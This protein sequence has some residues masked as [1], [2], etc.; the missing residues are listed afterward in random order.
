MR[1]TLQKILG[2]VRKVIVGKDGVIEKVLMAALAPGHVLLEDV[3]GV[4][5][6]TMTLAFAKALGLETRRIQFTSDTM[7]SDVAGFSSYDS[8]AEDFVYKPGAIMTN[9]LLADE[10]NRTSSKTQSALLEAMEEGRVTVDGVTRELPAPFLVLA[11]QNPAGSAGTQLLP[12]SQMDRFVIRTSIGYPDFQSQVSILRDRRDGNPLDK[13]EPVLTRGQLLEIIET[14]GHVFVRDTVY[15]YITSLVEASRTHPMVTLGL[16]PRGALALCRMTKAYALLAGRDYAAPEDAAAVF[17]D[18]AG[19]RLVLNAKA[20][21]NELGS[22][23][24]TDEILA[25][26]NMPVVREI[27]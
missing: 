18:V 26:V 9:L 21:F 23:G 20:R 3:P 19:H 6:T 2:E 27:K 22:Q 12:P 10:I 15:E 14:A 11:T 16:S 25:S 4:G 8:R 5:K 24:V 17:P 1:E 13:V 7:P